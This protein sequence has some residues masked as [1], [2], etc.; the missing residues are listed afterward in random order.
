VTEKPVLF[1]RSR[2]VEAPRA[3]SAAPFEDQRKLR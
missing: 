3:G 1:T 2:D